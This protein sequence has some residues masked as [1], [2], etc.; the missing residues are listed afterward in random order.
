MNPKLSVIVPVYNVSQYLNRCVDSLL[1]QTYD[2]YEIILVDDGS[3]DHCFEIMKSYES[4]QVL[5]LRK[6]NGGLSDARNFG[7]KYASGEYVVFI[8]SDDYILEGMFSK[9]MSH[10]FENDVVVCDMLYLYDDQR[11]KLASGGEFERICI[12]DN[13]AFILMNNSA[14]NK[15]IKKS[16]L[17]GIEF[18]KGMYYEDLATIPKILMKANS[19]YK[20]NDPFYVYYQRSSSIAHKINEKLFDIYQAIQTCI[21]EAKYQKLPQCIPYLKQ[22]YIIHGLDLTTLRIKDSNS[23]EKEMYLRKNMN[24]MR[25]YYP[26][27]EKDA[28]FRQFDMKKKIIFYLLKWHMESLVLKIYGK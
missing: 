12:Q 4:E 16:L 18:P 27:Y 25:Q 11:Q 10:T 9:M 24:Y 3:T 17:E 26:D 1:A 23:N 8:D 14:C 13:P 5:C 22:M 28:L 20:V 2:N 19:I 6:E 7:L 21:E 15:V